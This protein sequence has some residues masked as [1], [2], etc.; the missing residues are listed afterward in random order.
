VQV[1]ITGAGGFIGRHLVADQLRRGRGVTAVDLKLD[2]LRPLAA[3]PALHLLAGDFTDRAFLDLH[4]AGHDVCFHLAS[5]HLETG[6]DDAFFWRVNVEGARAFIER[7]H[8]AGIGRFV[9]CSSVGVFGD[10]RNPPADETTP[11]RPDITYE[12][13]KLAGEQAVLAYTQEAGNGFEV[14][15][16]RP[17]WVYGPG[18]PRTQ[19]LMRSIQKGRFF[20]V[21]DGRTLRHPIYIEDMT[22]GFELA[23]THPDAPGAVF[24]MAGPRAVT[25]RELTA[26]IA[27]CMG[28][29]PPRLKLPYL[30]V[31]PGCYLLEAAG[32]VLGREMPFTRR[33]LK[34]FTGNAAFDT[35]KARSMLGFQAQ[36]ELSE[37]LVRTYASYKNRQP[38]TDGRP[39]DG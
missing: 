8:R 12:K 35:T 19:K 31:W 7:C 39:T 20:F 29:S 5:A 23:A 16:V 6:V 9:H 14:V 33:S 28:V 2:A 3:N 26:E 4:L 17:S 27:N 24:I 21:G 11:C 37:G 25:L 30:L 1:L 10:V 38:T 34:F 13:S 15:V 18:C 36:T 32:A 22:A